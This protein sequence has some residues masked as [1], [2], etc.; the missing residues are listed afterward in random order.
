MLFVAEQMLGEKVLPPQVSI[1]L[2]EKNNWLDEKQLKNVFTLVI[3]SKVIKG[4]T[5]WDI[6]GI[7]IGI[8]LY[9]Y[10]FK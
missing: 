1:L 2:G 5:R 3:I 7:Y 6:E 10:E 8:N 9:H 4:T